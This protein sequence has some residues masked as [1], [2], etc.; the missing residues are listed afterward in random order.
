ML[1]L[2]EKFYRQD[3]TEVEEGTLES[4]LETSP[5]AADRFADLADEA[6]ARFG[7]PEPSESRSA[8]RSGWK[9]WTLA[10]VLLL[11][12]LWL[13]RRP[14]AISPDLK[15]EYPTP[16]IRFETTKTQ[17]LGKGVV[18]K[19]GATVPAH[20]KRKRYK[21]TVD[22]GRAGPV[23]VRILSAENLVAKELFSGPAV[24]GPNTFTWDGVLSDGS[25]A[26]PGNYRLEVQGAGRLESRYFTVK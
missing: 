25:L 14:A 19:T 11:G 9:V 1:E 20:P 2:V 3:L 10:L 26:P 24:E 7:L 16:A 22:I 17:P 8:G 6:Y 21:V 13:L 23:T 4:L 18:E 15:T 5:E 12:G